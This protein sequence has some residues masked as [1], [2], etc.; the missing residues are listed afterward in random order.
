MLNFVNH[1]RYLDKMDALRLLC[2]Q[3]VLRNGPVDGAPGVGPLDGLSQRQIKDVE[4]RSD[5][6]GMPIDFWGIT[7]STLP[8]PLPER[9]LGQASLTNVKG[10]LPTAD[11]KQAI[12]DHEQF[13]NSMLMSSQLRAFHRSDGEF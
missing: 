6:V 10:P 9:F 3:E 5:H 7:R 13:D 2:T 11:D 1:E 8:N 4:W 12:S